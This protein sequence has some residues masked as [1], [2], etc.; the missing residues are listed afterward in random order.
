MFLRYYLFRIWTWNFTI[1]LDLNPPLVKN[2]NPSEHFSNQCWRPFR[3]LILNDFWPFFSKKWFQN[4][5]MSEFRKLSKNGRSTCVSII[6]SIREHPCRAIS[7][8]MWPHSPKIFRRHSHRNQKLWF[9]WWYQRSTLIFLY[10]FTSYRDLEKV[11]PST[12]H[13]IFSHTWNNPCHFNQRRF[14]YECF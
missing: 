5:V 10:I 1:N 7:V 8:W 13:S 3:L 4:W 14:S 11:T 9:I 12:C 2:F 6:S